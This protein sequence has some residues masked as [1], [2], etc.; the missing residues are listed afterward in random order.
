MLPVGPSDIPGDSTVK[1]FCP[2]CE[3]IYHP[4]SSRY[5]SKHTRLSYPQY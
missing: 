3:D 2:K 4:K 5:H 1:L